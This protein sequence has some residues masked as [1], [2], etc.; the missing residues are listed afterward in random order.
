[1]QL[2]D[3][4]RLHDVAVHRAAVDLVVHEEVLPQLHASHG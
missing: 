4:V 2:A 3:L 1:M